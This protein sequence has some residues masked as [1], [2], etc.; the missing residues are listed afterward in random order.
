MG[1]YLLNMRVNLCDEEDRILFVDRSYSEINF[2]LVNY[3][4]FS[5]SCSDLARFIDM[6]KLHHMEVYP[7]VR[8]DSKEE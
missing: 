1:G 2:E 6:D 4:A 3:D 7:H 5:I 8:K